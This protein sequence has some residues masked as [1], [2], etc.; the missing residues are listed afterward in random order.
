MASIDLEGNYERLLG[1]ISKEMLSFIVKCCNGTKLEWLRIIKNHN[2]HSNTK[3]AVSHPETQQ[4][5]DTAHTQHRVPQPRAAD[6]P[7]QFGP[8]LHESLRTVADPEKTFDLRTSDYNGRRWR[9][10]GN[11]RHR[12]EFHQ[13]TCTNIH[14][15]RQQRC[16]LSVLFCCLL[17]RQSDRNPNLKALFSE[18]MCGLIVD[19]ASISDYAVSSWRVVGEWCVRNYVEGS[20]LQHGLRKYPALDWSDCDKPRKLSDRTV[21]CSGQISDQSSPDYKLHFLLAEAD[22]HGLLHTSVS[23]E[24]K[25]EWI[26]TF[27]S[28]ALLYNV[29]LKQRDKLA[30]ASALISSFTGNNATLI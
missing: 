1:K 21:G 28:P 4:T 10:A 19:A 11:Y 26:V 12:H 23:T 24:G 20:G 8:R 22:F 5:D 18:L 17:Q 14:K 7:E 6:V 27:T 15:Y 3:G 29:L 2:R 13:K 25:N 9:E 16:L 30:F